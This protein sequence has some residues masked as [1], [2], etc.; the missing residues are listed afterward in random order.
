[1]K[2][3]NFPWRFLS[4]ILKDKSVDLYCEDK[5]LEIWFYGLKY[6]TM[7]NNVEY[8]ILST[9][10]FVLNKIKL[11]IVIGLKSAMDKNNIQGN[12]EKLNFIIQKLCKEKAIQNISFTKLFLLYNKT[13]N[14]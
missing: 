4:V 1:M 11:K 8:K 9:N 13:V 14:L 5:Q 7:I 12:K 6:Y 10:K 2:L 3:L